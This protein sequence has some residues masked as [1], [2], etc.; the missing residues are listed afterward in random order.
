MKWLFFSLAIIGSALLFS[1]S[2]SSSS[3]YPDYSGTYS[4][5]Q[6]NLDITMQVFKGASPN[7]IRILYQTWSTPANLNDNHFMIV[8]TSFG[9]VT[10]S[11][12]GWF[13]KD[14]MFVSYNEPN[15]TINA[16]LVKQ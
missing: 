15:Y 16:A 7:Q 4:G 12:N 13:S 10:I 1:C 2:K 3:S 11:G 8:P 9:D 5:S 6:G 14:T